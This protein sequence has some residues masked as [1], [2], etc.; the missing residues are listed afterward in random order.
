M[1]PV[2][3]LSS[4]P[5]PVEAEIAEIVRLAARNGFG[6]L[7]EELKTFVGKFVQK[8][9]GE[10]S[11]IGRYLQAHCLFKDKIP[12]D[13]WVRK[14][15]DNHHLSLRK[16]SPK[17]K[18]QTWN[19]SDPFT[20]YEFYDLI[21]SECKRLNITDKPSHIFNCD[22]TAFVTDPSRWNIVAPTG[23]NRIQRTVAG[24]GKQSYSVLAC[25]S[26]DGNHLPPLIIFAAK[27]FYS[28]WCGNKP[29]PGTMY[30]KSGEFDLL[31]CQN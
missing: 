18:M 23:E 6:L 5:Y 20:I 10:D 19:A 9:S 3:I 7:R 25:V 8:H 27:N 12:S 14:F 16:P 24:S 1:A 30:A 28:N 11:D 4:L 21:E 29:Y 22:E 15:M 2:G 17:D 13:D 26:A 31:K